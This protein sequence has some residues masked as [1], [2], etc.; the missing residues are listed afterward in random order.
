MHG[1]KIVFI[2]VLW[3]VTMVMAFF[4]GKSGD[5]IEVV[6]TERVQT[7]YVAT[8]PPS[9]A[10]APA[11][12]EKQISLALPDEHR[13][14]GETVL[15]TNQDPATWT[16][17]ETKAKLV[18]AF[19][20]PDVAL[21]NMKISTIL[22][23]LHAGNVG[24]VLEIMQGMRSSVGATSLR[25]QLNDNYFRIFMQRWASLPG[26]G[27]AAARYIFENQGKTVPYAG[28]LALEGWASKDAA[29]AKAYVASIEDPELR[30]E[31]Q[32]GLVAGL[33]KNNIQEAADQSV[34]LPPGRRR[35]T[36]IEKVVDGWVDAGGVQAAINWAED[37]YEREEDP[38]YTRQVFLKMFWKVARTD[39]AILTGWMDQNSDNTYI[40]KGAYAAVASEWAVI[41]PP[42]AGQWLESNF[43]NFANDG[44]AAERLV[45]NWQRQDPAAAAAFVARN[46]D[47][48]KF[49]QNTVN[50]LAATWARTDPTKAMH[51]VA[52]LPDA[53]LQTEGVAQVLRSWPVD[54]L[55][56]ARTWVER[57]EPSPM[58][59]TARQSLSAR[60]QRTDPQGALQIAAGISDEAA[61]ATA[62]VD[63]ARYMYSQNADAVETWLP[64]SGIPSELH[65]VIRSGRPFNS[66]RR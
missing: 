60:M 20:E 23:N 10:T 65:P 27:E 35:N 44:F 12:T 37:V 21:R 45:D 34:N 53:D 6:E 25:D 33:A 31:M 46:F 9:S 58:M 7:K 2:G 56:Q 4:F 40:R 54:Q 66:P 3:L 49:N 61:R 30:A 55:G 32:F 26:H 18:E 39:P 17:E 64:V 11:A 42:A 14:P 13:E 43:E 36:S 57:A 28:T 59:D 48:G 50:G 38:E 16:A 41:D 8:S 15:S 63:S 24:A 62:L 51:W 5:R 19:L 52:G 22:G 47:S 29:A 1:K